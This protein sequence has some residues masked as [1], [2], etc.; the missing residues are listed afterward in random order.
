MSELGLGKEFEYGGGHEVRGRVAE[1]FKGFGIALGEEAEL[2]VFFD[3]LRQIN[4]LGL[5]AIVAR[6]DFGGECGVGQA[7]ADA[8]GDVEGGGAGGDFFD[9]AVGQLYVDEFGHD[10]LTY[11]QRKG[12]KS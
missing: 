4:E 5:V 7:R 2:D 8:A 1:D 11:G 6:T 10:G 9:A 3:G 12:C